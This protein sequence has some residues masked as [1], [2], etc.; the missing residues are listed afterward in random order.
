MSHPEQADLGALIEA[1]TSAGVEFIVVGGGAAVLHGAPITTRDLDI[2]PR[3]G[4]QNVDRL[5]A[6]LESLDTLVRDPAGR[7]LRPNRRALGG[8][9]QFLL[10]TRLG[11]LDCLM[12]LHDGRGFEELR[13]TSVALTDGVSTIQVVDLPT[14]IEIKAEAGR[15]KDRLALPILLAL[16]ADTQA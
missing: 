15:P 8:T 9:G 3:R 4:E 2:V 13:S 10:S 5:A 7:R 11:P 6:L 1:L 12:T 16:L 14:L